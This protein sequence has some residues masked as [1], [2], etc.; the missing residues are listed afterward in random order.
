MIVE[1]IDIRPD[2]SLIYTYACM[3]FL[4]S[5]KHS[6]EICQITWFVFNDIKPIIFFQTDSF[7]EFS[8]LK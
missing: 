4:W 1:S 8:E 5:G 7:S 2:F 6:T 3:F